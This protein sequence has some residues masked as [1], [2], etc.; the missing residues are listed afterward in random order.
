MYF[1]MDLDQRT[2]K[3][4]FLSDQFHQPKFILKLKYLP[5]WTHIKYFLMSQ[6]LVHQRQKCLF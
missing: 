1:P 2:K 6:V 4:L 3:C 5:L